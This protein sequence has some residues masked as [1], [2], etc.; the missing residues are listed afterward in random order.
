MIVYSL[1]HVIMTDWSDDVICM[2]HN[3]NG[4]H[5]CPLVGLVMLRGGIEFFSITHPSK[6]THFGWYGRLNNSFAKKRFSVALKRWFRFKR[7]NCLA[8][9]KYT[10]KRHMCRFWVL[11]HGFEWKRY[12]CALFLYR[13]RARDFEWAEF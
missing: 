11:L 7:T 8:K 6:I 5:L 3:Y 4:T 9:I 10:T 2:V 1:I 12:V 13:T